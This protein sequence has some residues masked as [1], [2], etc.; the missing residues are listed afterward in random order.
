M[1]TNTRLLNIKTFQDLDPKLMGHSS[2]EEIRDMFRQ[3]VSAFPEGP[4]PEDMETVSDFIM[5]LARIKNLEKAQMVVLSLE[6]IAKRDTTQLPWRQFA[7][8]LREKLCSIVENLYQLR[9]R[10]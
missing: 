9:L 2:T 5:D 4:E 1:D 10:F 7:E 6:Q 3:W 8:N